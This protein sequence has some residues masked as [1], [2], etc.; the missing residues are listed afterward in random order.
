MQPKTR[1]ITY[2][3]IISVNWTAINGDSCSGG[4]RGQGAAIHIIPPP[5]NA[6]SFRL[7]SKK[8]Q[9]RHER[10]AGVKPTG[11][12]VVVAAPPVGAFPVHNEAE[13]EGHDE[14]AGVVDGGSRRHHG[15]GA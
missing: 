3:K 12:D 9:H 7:H 6:D 15:G 5:I 11:Q 10:R 14:P 2:I 8:Q 4:T 13:D 1:S